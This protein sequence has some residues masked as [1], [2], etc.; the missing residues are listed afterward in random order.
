MSY[1]QSIA[2][3]L[4]EELKQFAGTIET[5]MYLS[6]RTL[7]GV[8]AETFDAYC[9]EAVQKG[10]RGMAHVRDVLVSDGEMAEGY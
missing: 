8:P 4:P 10:V 6:N 7:D 3:R 2:D 9:A 1:R 5:W